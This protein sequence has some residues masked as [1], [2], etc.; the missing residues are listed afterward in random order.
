MTRTKNVRQENTERHR[1]LSS[2]SQ[3]KFSFRQCCAMHMHV[4]F[5]ESLS[6]QHQLMLE[7][8]SNWTE[9][10][11]SIVASQTSAEDVIR[12]L[13]T[14]SRHSFVSDAVK[15]MLKMMWNICSIDLDSQTIILSRFYLARALVVTMT[16]IQHFM[17]TICRVKR[18]RSKRSAVSKKLMN[19]EKKNQKIENDSKKHT[20]KTRRTAIEEI[21]EASARHQMW[22]IMSKI[23]RNKSRSDKRREN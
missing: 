16:M 1:K 21:K 9:Q 5:I 17:K 10:C 8:Q 11:D 2:L 14:V 7:T 19:A 20:W 18:T 13:T 23:V 22:K 12:S 4:L 15:N 6:R 3:L